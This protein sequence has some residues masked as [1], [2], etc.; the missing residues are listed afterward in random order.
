MARN[1]V[2]LVNEIAKVEIS[3]K[4]FNFY[5]FATKYCSHH[6]PKDYPIYD[7]YVDR[8]LMAFKKPY[9]CVNKN[10]QSTDAGALL[11]K[12]KIIWTNYK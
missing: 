8:L 3:G 12:S 6:K 9:F 5:S 1:D 7:N 10:P 11:Q 4:Q 2:S